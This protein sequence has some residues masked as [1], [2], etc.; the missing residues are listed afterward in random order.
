M[1]LFRKKKVETESA[2]DQIPQESQDKLIEDLM[3]IV[4]TVKAWP[5]LIPVELH[6]PIADE[7][8]TLLRKTGLKLASAFM[9]SG[10]F[11]EGMADAFKGVAVPRLFTQ[12]FIAIK[13]AL[14]DKFVPPEEGPPNGK[15]A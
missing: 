4:R 8:A 7:V 3:S 10:D 15:A 14:T 6:A 2:F 13:L 1:S 5:G 12:G 11:S 9:G